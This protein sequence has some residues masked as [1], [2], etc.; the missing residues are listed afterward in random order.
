MKCWKRKPERFTEALN[1]KDVH[2]NGTLESHKLKIAVF[3]FAFMNRISFYIF[4]T[5]VTLIGWS[6]EVD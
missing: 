1:L 3:F 2:Q 6:D 4:K 5:K